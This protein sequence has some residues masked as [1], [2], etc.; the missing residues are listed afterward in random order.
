M[1]G[2]KL[3]DIARHAGVSPATVTRVIHGSGYVSAEKKAR[4]E[5]AMSELGYTI[6][7]RPDPPGF[8][9]PY[10]IVISPVEAGG[11]I[12]FHQ[13]SERLGIAL[14]AQGWMMMQH[15]IHDDSAMDLV[16]VIERA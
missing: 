12:L 8:L 2:V 5:A 14:Q 3:Q 11:N 16:R 1:K 15:F 6:A 10:V 13:I 7:P 9:E 4:V